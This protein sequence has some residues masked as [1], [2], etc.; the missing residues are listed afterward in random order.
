MYKKSND[1]N[2][3]CLCHDKHRFVLKLKSHWLSKVRWTNTLYQSEL[4][5]TGLINQHKKL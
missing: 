4:A 3:F 1:C 5:V 2:S